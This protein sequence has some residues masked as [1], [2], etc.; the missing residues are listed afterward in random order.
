MASIVDDPNGR[1]RILF[2]D[3]HDRRRVI[4]LGKASIKQ[5]ET[6]KAKIEAIIADLIVG[7]SHDNEI[8]RWL[9]ELDPKFQVRLERAGLLKGASGHKATLQAFLDDFFA[10]VV[11]KTST[12]V[13]YGQTKRCLLD[14]FGAGKI[15]REIGPIDADKWRQWL[16][17]QGLAES[18]ISRRVKCARQMFKR[19]MK[20]RL[21]GE[22]PFADV[23]AGSQTNKARMYFVTCKEAEAVL[24]ACPDA[25]WR[26][27]F[28]L[29]RYGGLR[30]PSEHFALTWSDVDWHRSRI[31][32]PSCKTE[33]YEGGDCRYIPLFPELRPYLMEVFEQAEPG[34]QHVITR[35]RDAKTNLRTQ[36]CRIIRKA[37]LKPWP[38]LF[39]NLRSTRQTELAERYP[40]HVVCAWLGNSRAV[41]QEHYLQVTDAHFAHAAKGD[42]KAAQIPA[43]QAAESGRGTSQTPHPENKNRPEFPSD[44]VSCDI[45]QDEGMTPTGFEPVSRP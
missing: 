40:I 13:T 7:R 43:Q 4:R 5:A 21:I 27:L 29:S 42:E 15:L 36:L 31:R 35:Y 18:T 19:A 6:F 41:A 32:V 1:K 28:A 3:G 14:H 34:S 17:S 44:S 10:S 22:N 12:A 26:L 9:R 33:H 11:T 25:Q 39:H 38:K 37:G 30:C 45:L 20:W 23:V 16:K 2:V 8:A 24:I